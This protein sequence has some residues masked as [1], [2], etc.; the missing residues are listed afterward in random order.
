MYDLSPGVGAQRRESC[1]L[2]HT[3]HDLR[4]PLLKI[5]RL[6]GISVEPLSKWGFILCLHCNWLC[7]FYPLLK[8]FLPPT[9]LRTSQPS[10][11][12]TWLPRRLAPPPG[13]VTKGWS[14]SHSRGGSVCG[15]VC[16]CVG[17]MLVYHLDRGVDRAFGR[18]AVGVLRKR[19]FWPN[20][21]IFIP[22][23]LAISASNDFVNRYFP[24]L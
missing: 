24:S 10:S 6:A 18:W 8:V 16:C 20:V 14:P 9:V 7:L 12:S 21:L 23:R 5:H 13:H 22:P 15:Y 3:S 19:L 11:C 17:V 2:Q 4:I 1:D